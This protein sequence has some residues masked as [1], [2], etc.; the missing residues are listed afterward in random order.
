MRRSVGAL[1]RNPA[2]R[3]GLLIVGLL[4]LGAA[5]ADW[6]PLRSP[7]RMTPGDRMAG[8][9]KKTS[10]ARIRTWSSRPPA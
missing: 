2:A 6:L 3:A 10:M 1:R 7:L 8:N 4:V 5:A 9:E